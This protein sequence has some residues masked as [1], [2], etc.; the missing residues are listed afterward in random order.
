MLASQQVTSFT[1]TYYKVFFPLFF[2]GEGPPGRRLASQ[3]QN[4]PNPASFSGFGIEILVC[5]PDR[6]E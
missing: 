6:S 4:L 2:G 3:H 5:S 1:L